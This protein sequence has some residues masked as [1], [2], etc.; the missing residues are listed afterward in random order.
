MKKLNEREKIALHQL[1]LIEIENMRFI[2]YIPSLI[3]IVL[4]IALMSIA[5]W[6]KK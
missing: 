2:R 5:F 3:I 1:K 6:I 4:G